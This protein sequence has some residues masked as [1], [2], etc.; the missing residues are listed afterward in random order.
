MPVASPHFQ[1]YESPFM[2]LFVNV[3]ALPAHTPKGTV[4]ATVPGQ[5]ALI[6][7][8]LLSNK[9]IIKYVLVYCFFISRNYDKL[10]F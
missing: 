1:I 5:A 8:T 6:F 4:K 3:A 9:K 2:V 10:W 7:D